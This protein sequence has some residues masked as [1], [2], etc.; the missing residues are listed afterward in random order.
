MTYPQEILQGEVYT[1]ST[2]ESYFFA[3]D[4]LVGIVGREDL[5][6]DNPDGSVVQLKI[7]QARS[8]RTWEE[9][10]AG[11]YYVTLSPFSVAQF[12]S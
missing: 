2:F 6:E 11:V 12:L 4:A 7:E 8:E 3:A 1:Q 9:C 5:S 10:V